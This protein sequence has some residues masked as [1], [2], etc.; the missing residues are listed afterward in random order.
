M[1]QHQTLQSDVMRL[2]KVPVMERQEVD[3]LG[4]S[5]MSGFDEDLGDLRLVLRREISRLDILPD[6]VVRETI[7]EDTEEYCSR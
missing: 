6:I 5:S 3:S 1:F 7:D 4:S 2:V